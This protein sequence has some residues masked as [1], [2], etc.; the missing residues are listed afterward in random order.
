[1][2]RLYL[3]N[4]E[5][6]DGLTIHK[7]DINFTLYPINHNKVFFGYFYQHTLPFLIN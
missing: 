3:F 4:T 2:G 7:R 1:M 5:G 6:Q